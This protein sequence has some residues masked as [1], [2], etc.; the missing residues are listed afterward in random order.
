MKA[1]YLQMH[2]L[3]LLLILLLL[4][5]LLLLV[6]FHVATSPV[7]VALLGMPFGAFYLQGFI[8]LRFLEKNNSTYYRTSN[9]KLR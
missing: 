2:C 8:K 5:L 6:L 9:L 4:L 3:K 1:K 7:H